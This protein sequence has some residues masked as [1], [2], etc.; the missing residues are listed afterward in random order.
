MQFQHSGKLRARL[1]L[2]HLFDNPRMGRELQKAA[3][4]PS[5]GPDSRTGL[6][7]G[8]SMG[9]LPMGLKE[10]SSGGHIF[11][12]SRYVKLSTARCTQLG[13]VR[14]ASQAQFPCPCTKV[15]SVASSLPRD[16]PATDS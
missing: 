14:N 11:L 6:N 10:G 7:D 12:Q 2:R 5:W 9:R 8:R 13:G 1:G 16:S 3:E 4:F 15:A